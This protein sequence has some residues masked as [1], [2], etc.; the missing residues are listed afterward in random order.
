MNS[1]F[2]SRPPRH[3]S[4]NPAQ[5][6]R[7]VIARFDEVVEVG[8]RAVL[9]PAD[10]VLEGGGVVVLDQDVEHVL[11]VVE[12]EGL[13]SDLATCGEETGFF[14]FVMVTD[15]DLLGLEERESIDPVS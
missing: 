1:S 11:V 6:V 9:G 13:L 12:G 3:S 8:H 5:K 4:F 14:C 7:P 15:H 10:P 2:P